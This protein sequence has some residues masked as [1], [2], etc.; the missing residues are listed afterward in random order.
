MSGSAPPLPGG[1]ASARD[2]DADARQDFYE[3]GKALDQEIRANRQA[4]RLGGYAV[5]AAGLLVG[6]AGLASAALMLPLK[7]T[8]VRFVPF[9]LATQQVVP[10][11]LAQDAPAALFREQQAK[12]DLRKLVAAAETY[13]PDLYALNFHQV[14]VMSDPA[15]QARFAE[16]LS[17]KNPHSPAAQYRNQTSVVVDRFQFWP[18]GKSGNAQVWRVTFQRT[19]IAGGTQLAARPYEAVVTFTWRPD[20]AAVS[21]DDRAL[22][23][24]GFQCLDYRSGTT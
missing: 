23:L 4:I 9:D 19:E 13:V 21:E 14:A 18:L 16:E 2:L 22:N 11:V 1:W 6:I 15:M 24:T 20:L 8:E 12:A 3:Q 5:G 7:R 10:S 17:P